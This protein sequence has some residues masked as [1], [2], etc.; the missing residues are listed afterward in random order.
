M[1][2]PGGQAKAFWEPVIMTSAFN[3][4]ISNSS[5]KKALIQSTINSILFLLQKSLNK[6]IS[7][8]SPVDVS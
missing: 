8:N 2:I 6:F 4:S 7:Y 3:F 5:A 1:E